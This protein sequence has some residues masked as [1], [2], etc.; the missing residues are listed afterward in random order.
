M[1]KVKRPVCE[2][3]HSCKA[4]IEIRNMWSNI[5]TAPVFLQA[6]ICLFCIDKNKKK[7]IYSYTTIKHGTMCITAY[8]TLRSL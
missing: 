8:I 1:C 5:S 2:S 7:T 3:D 6:S 4:S